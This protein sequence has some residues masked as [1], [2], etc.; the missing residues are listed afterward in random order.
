MI[1]VVLLPRS[2]RYCA[3]F[4][5]AQFV[6]ELGILRIDLSVLICGYAAQIL[7]DLELYEFHD[8]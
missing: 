7:N 1:H 5:P 3:F 6:F 2:V 4:S 8:S